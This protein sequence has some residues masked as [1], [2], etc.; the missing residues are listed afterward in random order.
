MFGRDELC[1]HRWHDEPADSL[2]A[3]CDRASRETP[4]PYFVK[5]NGDGRLHF[6]VDSSMLTSFSKCPT[7]FRYQYVQ[8]QRRKGMPGAMS[9]GGWWSKVLELFYTNMQSRQKSNAG[10]VTR[11]EM[12]AFAASAWQSC[13]MEAMK[14][15]NA[16]AYDAFGGPLGAAA[17]ASEYYDRIGGID[18]TNLKIISSEAGFGLR[19]EMVLFE[20]NE[21][22]IHYIGKP[23]LTVYDSASKVLAPLDHK[24]VDRIKSDIQRKYKPHGQTCGYIWAIGK[25]AKSLGFDIPVDR[26]I[27][28]I[29]ARLPPAE[30]PKDGKPKPRFTRV[31]PTY[32]PDEIEEW[33]LS[34]LSKV[35]A[36]RNA[37][38]TDSWYMSDSSCHLYGGCDFRLVDSVAPANR[39]IVLRSDYVTVEPWVPYEVEDEQTG[40]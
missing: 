25:L 19:G 18:N 11:S 36:I 7:L 27:I 37:I 20:D 21:I 38:L 3:M 2:A 16:K 23:D 28:N 6:S 14:L 8:L 26:C 31:Y 33:R 30:K 40:E 29:A 15:Q 4:L 10:Y 5:Q 17:M 32:S 22:V 39:D 12:M 1:T 9:I 35:R 34:V 24:T 13:N